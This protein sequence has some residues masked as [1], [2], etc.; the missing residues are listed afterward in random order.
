V[1]IEH[2]FDPRQAIVDFDDFARERIKARVK[3]GKPIFDAGEPILDASEPILNASEPG[4][5]V[6]FETGQTRIQGV[7]LKYHADHAHHN[8][9]HRY[10][11]REIQLSVIH[12]SSSL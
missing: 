1:A 9:E 5:D 4:V 7:E 10:A 6:R 2:R 12:A 8:G 11:D 3:A